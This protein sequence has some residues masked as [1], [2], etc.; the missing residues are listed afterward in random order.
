MPVLKSRY[1]TYTIK[2]MNIIKFANGFILASFLMAVSGAIH[3]KQLVEKDKIETPA[4]VVAYQA[5]NHYDFL[6]ELNNTVKSSI[7]KAGFEGLKNIFTYQKNSQI[8]INVIHDPFSGYQD[9]IDDIAQ[10]ASRVNGVNLQD[11]MTLHILESYCKNGNFYQIQAKQ[12]DEQV[13]VQYETLNGK[14]VAVHQ[15]NR[16]LCN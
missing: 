5:F 7:I 3:A 4:N 11:S 2:T 16:Q 12:L 1:E 14:R 10:S 8:V 13:R 9:L 15:I 6:A